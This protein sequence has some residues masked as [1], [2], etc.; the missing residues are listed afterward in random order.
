MTPRIHTVMAVISSIVVAAVVAWGFV[1]VGSPVTRRLERFDEQRLEDLRT[2]AR[3]I[4]S[5]VEDRDNA[6]SLKA[7]LPKNLEEA[8]QRARDE[9]LNPRDPESGIAYT[10]TVINSSTYELCATFSLPRD[11]DSNVFWNH[12]AGPHCFR[13]DVND[14]PPY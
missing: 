11:W 4:Q 14:P 3:E 7:P 6:G 2:I 12:P 13:I 9:R 1:L 8:A 5:M 10:Y